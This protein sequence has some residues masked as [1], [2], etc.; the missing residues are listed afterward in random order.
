MT[1]LEKRLD[2]LPSYLFEPFYF[3]TLTTEMERMLEEFGTGRHAFH[4]VW[5]KPETEVAWTPR[6][7]IVLEHDELMVRAE[8]P[9]IE[10]KDVTV[11]VKDERLILKG[12]RHKTFKTS[13]EEFIKTE[14]LYGEFY[15]AIPLPEGA[16]AEAATAVFVNGVLE[17]R[18]PVPPR[19]EPK[20]RK[21]NVEVKP[22][23][24]I[25]PTPL[26]KQPAAV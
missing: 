4:R 9:G 10:P 7:E 11:E 12:T 23:L 19:H 6:I 20:T 15:R 2:L 22:V 3:G 16:I 14:R 18:L 8:L 24:E 25:P 1:S 5:Q 13:K 17:I 21:V 26:T